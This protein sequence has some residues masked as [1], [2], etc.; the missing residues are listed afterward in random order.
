MIKERQYYARQ[1]H[2]GQLILKELEKK[3]R[4]P[5]LEP[6]QVAILKVD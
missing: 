5:L 4:K 1:K 3:G 6:H 2:Y